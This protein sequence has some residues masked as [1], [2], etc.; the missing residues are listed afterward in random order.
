MT[1]T[2][3]PHLVESFFREH[4]QRIRGA[5]PHTILSYRDSVSLLLRFLADRRDG[6]LLTFVWVSPVSAG[7]L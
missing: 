5:S 7:V 1:S 4:L 6:D 3:L 2:D